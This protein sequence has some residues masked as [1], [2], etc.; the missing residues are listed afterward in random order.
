MVLRKKKTFI[1]LG[2]TDKGRPSQPIFK[3]QWLAVSSGYALCLT[4][5]YQYIVKQT[6]DA[7]KENDEQCLS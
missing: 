3:V 6:D 7:D 4:P 1:I 5:L 2:K